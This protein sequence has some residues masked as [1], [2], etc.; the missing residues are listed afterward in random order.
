MCCSVKSDFVKALE[1]LLAQPQKPQ[2]IVIETTG[3][4]LQLGAGCRGVGVQR[5][6]R[7]R[8]GEDRHLLHC[9]LGSTC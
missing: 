4:L 5:G 9:G 3:K 6:Q 1:S 7:R 8:R 2:Y